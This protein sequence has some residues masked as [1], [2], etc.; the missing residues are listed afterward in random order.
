VPDW[1]ARLP[2]GLRRNLR[3]YREQLSR[4]AAIEFRAGAA[5]QDLAPLFGLHRIRW[6]EMKGESG[7]LAEPGVEPFHRH[8]AEGF[9]RRGWLRV[10]RLLAGGL[11]ACVIYGFAWRGLAAFYIS[12]FDPRW[13]RYGPGTLT[14]GFAV[15]DLIA[16]GVRELHFLRGREPYKYVWGARDRVNRTLRLAGARAAGPS[17][18]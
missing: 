7:V 1:A 6:G 8:V 11:P 16:E 18:P 5:P 3:R 14:I 10:W 12:G 15:E 2:R 9:S 4:E 17:D 13:A